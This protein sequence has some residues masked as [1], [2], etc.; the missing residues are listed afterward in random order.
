MID[1]VSRSRPSAQSLDYFLFLVCACPQ[2]PLLALSGHFAPHGFG[3]T[4]FHAASL[5][6]DGIVKVV[7]GN[8]FQQVGCQL[9]FTDADCS[10]MFTETF[11]RDA[12]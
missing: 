1:L 12:A 9:G 11:H 4:E 10:G 8:C 2:C 6:Q 5:V 3:V 7:H